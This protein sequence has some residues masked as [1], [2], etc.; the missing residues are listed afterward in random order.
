MKRNRDLIRSLLLA[1]EA[2]DH[3]TGLDI[4]GRF[5]PYVADGVFSLYGEEP[6]PEWRERDY[7]L[8]LMESAGLVEFVDGKPDRD[9][10]GGRVRLTPAGHDAIEAISDDRFWGKLKASTPREAYA[11]QWGQG[12]L[13]A[14]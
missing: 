10:Y 7:N 5:A 14:Q 12:P 4:P 13:S 6:H 9:F 8:I 3:P 1:I 11:L 2:S